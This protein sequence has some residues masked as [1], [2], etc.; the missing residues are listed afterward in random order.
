MKMV[1]ALADQSQAGP[2]LSV[3][4]RR[5]PEKRGPRLLVPAPLHSVGACLRPIRSRP[6]RIWI[7]K[8][9]V[10]RATLACTCGR[11]LP[12][13]SSCQDLRIPPRR[14]ASRYI[15][16]TWVPLTVIGV[17]LNTSPKLLRLVGA[18]LC[19]GNTRCLPS[20]ETQVRFPPPAQFVQGCHATAVL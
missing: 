15:R 4:V 2:C 8:G 7:G 19:N 6:G 1:V 5:S 3:R 18:V 14:S 9:P 17:S 10:P 16:A 12:G 20:K 11:P 13:R